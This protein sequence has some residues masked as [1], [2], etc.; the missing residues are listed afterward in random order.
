MINFSTEF[1]HAACSRMGASRVG[2]MPF[3]H[4]DFFPRNVSFHK[5][6]FI[7]LG[8]PPVFK[9]P[10]RHLSSMAVLV[11]WFLALCNFLNYFK[12]GISWCFDANKSVFRSRRSDCSENFLKATLSFFWD[13][14]LL[15]FTRCANYRR[16][17][18]VTYSKH[19]KPKEKN[20]WWTGKSFDKNHWL[21][22]NRD[23]NK[24]PFANVKQF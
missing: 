7:P 16:F 21:P 10:K 9:L 24:V 2:S 19:Q 17:H 4:C 15:S 13:F 20:F 1:V 6:V 11:F 23:W 12:W 8:F 22:K 3:R 14:A 18:L 5:R